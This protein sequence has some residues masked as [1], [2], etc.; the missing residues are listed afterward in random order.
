MGNN[1]HYKF[2]IFYVVL[3][4]N[5]RFSPGVKSRRYWIYLPTFAASNSRRFSNQ[6][7]CSGEVV[8]GFFRLVFPLSF[9]SGV[10]RLYAGAG[11]CGEKSI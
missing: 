8:T 2:H 6:Y 10:V 1:N 9:A 7:V 11:R 4:P 3:L 5:R